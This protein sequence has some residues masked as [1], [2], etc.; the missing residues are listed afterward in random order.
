MEKEYKN[1]K[2]ILIGIIIALIA[3][4]ISALGT[5]GFHKYQR[6]NYYKTQKKRTEHT[7]ES[8]EDRIKHYVKK[9][10]NLNEK[11]CS[12][13]CRSM[14]QNFSQTKLMLEKIG[15][16]KREIIDQTL[17]ANPDTAKLNQLCDSLGYF[18]NKMQRGMNRHFLEVKNTL[19]SAQLKR[20]KEILINISEKDGGKDDHERKYRNDK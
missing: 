8:R 9:E 14:D 13:Y 12:T 1:K 17:A 3:I 20:L 18:H 7:K 15:K 4:N 6:N 11:Q 2:R 5:W 19:D 10:L 16:C